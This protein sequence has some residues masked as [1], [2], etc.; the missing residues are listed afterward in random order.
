MVGQLGFS[1]STVSR[2]YQEYMGDGE[3]KEKIAI[4][5]TATVAL[6]APS[7]P[8]PHN[9][10]VYVIPLDCKGQLALTVH[11][12]RQL[13]CIVHIQQSQTLAQI[14]TQFNDGANCTVSKRTGLPSLHCVGF[15]SSQ[16]T[17]VSLLNACHRA[18]R[19]ACAR[20]HRD[21]GVDWK[22]VAWSDESR[23]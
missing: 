3:K 22:L 19:L 10:G 14:N 1:R 6:S 17:R 8:A 5:Q 23:F 4:G 7:N 18:A 2:I 9:A 13:R 16:H 20:E 11:G 15:G 12:E 21:W